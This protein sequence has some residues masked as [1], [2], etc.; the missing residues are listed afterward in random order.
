MV[1][2]AHEQAR[3]KFASEH[4]SD[5]EKATKWSDEAKKLFSINP[6]RCFRRHINAKYDPKNTIPNVKR[7]VRNF[8]LLDYLQEGYK[9]TL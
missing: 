5:S 4:L 7:G 6:T 9:K 3:V 1:K 8:L 2:K